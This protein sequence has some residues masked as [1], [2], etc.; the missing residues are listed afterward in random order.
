LMSKKDARS[1]DDE[2]IMKKDNVLFEM[3][4][5]SGFKYSGYQNK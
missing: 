3:S 5:A 4:D 1:K 2:D